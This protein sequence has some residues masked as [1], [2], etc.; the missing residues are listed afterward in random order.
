M[1]RFKTAYQS[2]LTM[3]PHGKEAYL[4]CIYFNS[5]EGQNGCDSVTKNNFVRNN[6][7]RFG[8]T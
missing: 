8:A 4:S 2:S 7:W 3:T 5:P 1:L 6:F